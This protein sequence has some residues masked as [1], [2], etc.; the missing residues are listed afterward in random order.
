[1]LYFPPVGHDLKN[2]PA[3]DPTCVEKGTVEYWKCERCGRNFSDEEGKNELTAIE[4]DAPL[5]PHTYDTDGS[6]AVCSAKAAAG[7]KAADAAAT[8]W[9]DTMAAAL[10]KLTAGAQLTV[11]ANYE[12]AIKLNKTCTVVVKT[13]VTVSKI[14]TADGGDFAVT[15]INNGTINELTGYTGKVTLKS[16]IGTYGHITDNST[17]GDVGSFLAPNCRYR[18]GGRWLAPDETAKNTLENGESLC[19]E[20]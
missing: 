5:A 13:G 17:S 18:S 15:V 2:V 12:S 7:V 19:G 8:T 3:K 11:N 20:A 10:G 9:Y 6:C 4:T 1:M 16:G 14:E